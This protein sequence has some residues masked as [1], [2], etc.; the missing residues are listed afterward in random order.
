[1]SEMVE[2]KVP[3]IGDFEGVEVIEVL[4]AEGDSVAEEDSLITVESDKAAMEIPSS[5]SGVVKAVKVNIGDK[6]S[7]GSVVILLEAG[8]AAVDEI[9]VAAV[10]PEDVPAEVLPTPKVE[11]PAAV[12]EARP[13]PAPT[14]PV[15]RPSPTANIDAVS[16]VKAHASP[17]V[18]KFARELGVDLSLL[19]GSGRN[20]RIVK[21][22]IQN[23]VKHA[24]ERNLVYPGRRV[25]YCKIGG[26]CRR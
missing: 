8:A 11:T 10:E 23:F 17:S 13:A 26:R 9:P 25:Q 6:V 16:F 7:E 15:E 19:K 14:V 5:H 3:D 24:L 22:D 18:R 2:V 20:G 1:M 4:V 12:A 21:D